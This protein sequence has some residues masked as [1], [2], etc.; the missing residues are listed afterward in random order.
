MKIKRLTL[1]TRHTSHEQSAGSKFKQQWLFLDRHKRKINNMKQ[2]ITTTQEAV[3]KKSVI[4]G[5]AKKV[6]V[7]MR[8]KQKYGPKPQAVQHLSEGAEK[9]KN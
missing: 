1:D 2:K 6:R 7:H 8:I 3:K 4:S 5:S 9:N